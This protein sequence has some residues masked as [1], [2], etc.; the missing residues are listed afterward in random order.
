MVPE[1]RPEAESASP[2]LVLKAILISDRVRLAAIEERLVTEGE[3]IGEERVLEIKPDRVILGK[4]QKKR[5]LYLP[6]SAVPLIV[7]ER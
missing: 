1:P 3:V 2:A 6:Q 7:E 5:T 4:G